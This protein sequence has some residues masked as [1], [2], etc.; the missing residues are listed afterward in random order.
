MCENNYNM[1]KYKD[2][3]LKDKKWGEEK[4]KQQQFI[5]AEK[6]YKDYIKRIVYRSK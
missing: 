1:N 4:E 5:K 2:N 6:S 3:K